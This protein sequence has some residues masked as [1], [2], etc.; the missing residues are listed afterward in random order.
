[1]TQDH[2]IIFSL[3]HQCCSFGNSLLGCCASYFANSRIFHIQMKNEIHLQ[4]LVC[5]SIYTVS[6]V[7][8]HRYNDRTKFLVCDFLYEIL[9]TVFFG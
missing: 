9:R 7:E 2:L 8:V 4:L 6:P 1:M 5:R 3:I